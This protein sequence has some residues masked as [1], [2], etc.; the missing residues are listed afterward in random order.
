MLATVIDDFRAMCQMISSI[1]TDMPGLVARAG[2][3]ERI[4]M[5]VHELVSRVGMRCG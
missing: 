4:S 2:L 1:L 3:A 5:I